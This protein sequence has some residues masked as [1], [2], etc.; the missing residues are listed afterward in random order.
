V[1]SGGDAEQLDLLDAA[2][3]AVQDDVGVR[4]RLLATLTAELLYTP[5]TYDRFE[6]AD[7]ALRLARESGDPEVIFDV[8]FW[9]ALAARAPGRGQTGEEEAEL[10]EL[11]ATL[12]DPLR[13]AMADVTSVLRAFILGD[14]D[15]A[16][17]P[18]HAATELAADLRVPVLH[19]LVTV[20][21]A[22]Y[23][24]A[25]GDLVEGERLAMQGLELSQA[26][27]QPDTATWF[28]VQLYM[29]RLE[30][31]RLAEITDLFA[32]ALSRASSLYT[33]HA[34]LALALTETGEPARARE[35]VAQ[36]M[37]VDYPA[38]PG[39]PH[40]LVGM[41]CLGS[42]VA[43]LGDVAT[44]KVVYDALAP[45]A[46]HWASIMPLTL[47]S[48]ERVLGSLALALGRP[49]D[50]ER[51]F[52]AAIAS[53]DAGGAVSFAARSRVGLV[54]AL[55]QQGAGA[56]D[57]ELRRLIADVRGEVERHGLVRVGEQLD[58]VLAVHEDDVTGAMM[59]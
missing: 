19:W 15:G 41:S 59:S 24:I 49:H 17:P 46:A 9:R 31:S 27:D 11:A 4:A 12:Q 13:T 43:A 18:L 14:L 7:E 48:N 54:D 30:Q 47:G 5:R 32:A 57:A 39:E 21:R 37:A 33:W 51:H 23:A 55:L 35:L 38:H 3:A 20:L 42:T 36:M 28:G 26:T 6:T 1:A 2:L 25:T 29:I 16:L 40:W 34:A 10:H 52:R 56:A 45:C 8:L 58:A 22:T 50:A 53:N 44:A